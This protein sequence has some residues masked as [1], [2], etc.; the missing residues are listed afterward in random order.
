MAHLEVFAPLVVLVKVPLLVKMEN[1]G[2]KS[3][4]KNLIIINTIIIKY[5]FKDAQLIQVHSEDFF[6]Q[7]VHVQVNM[8]VLTE[9]AGIFVF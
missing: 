7:D 1:A 9:L 4:L 6:H 3:F 8:N 5:F 2:K